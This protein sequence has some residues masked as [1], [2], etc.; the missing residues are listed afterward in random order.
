MKNITVNTI[1]HAPVD[2]VWKFWSTPEHIAQWNNVNDDWH[3]PK[4][5]N[6]LQDEGK[7]FYRMET[8]DGSLGFD[9]RGKYDTVVTH[10]L[11]EY[12][13]S[14]GRKSSILFRQDG[15]KT[16][17]TETFDPETTTPLDE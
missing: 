13:L 7:F 15:E 5:E 14:D 17:I 2:K 4:V 12:T 3:T 10:E 8:K 11:I 9:H 6:D 1:V 16:D